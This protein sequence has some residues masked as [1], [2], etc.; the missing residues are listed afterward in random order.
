MEPQPAAPVT[1]PWGIRD[2]VLG[3]VAGFVLSNLVGGIVLAAGGYLSEGA[4]DPPLW[5]V[6][7][8]QI[9]LWVGLGGA[10]A[11][12]VRRS[13][14]TLGS[15]LG[16]TMERRDAPIGLGIGVLTQLVVVPLLY[17]PI[18][19]A[20]DIDP[21]EVSAPARALTDRAEGIGILVL[22]LVVV[23]GAPIVEELFFRGLLLRSVEQRYGPAWGLWVSSVVFGL[24]HFQLLQLPALVLFGVVAGL[25]TQRTGRLGPAIWAHAG[26][27][28]VTV[29]VLV[30][31]G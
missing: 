23:V 20:F 29:I 12:A 18:L 13:G 7:L 2:A 11:L 16:F 30:A 8:L 17:V 10:V 19:W 27:N 21:G 25:L 9:P 15:Q 4:G 26:F 5:L 6:A 1:R 22:A 24:F 28:A 3:L 31:I 14:G